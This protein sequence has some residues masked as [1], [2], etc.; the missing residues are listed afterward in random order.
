MPHRPLPIPNC[1]EP[2]Q[3]CR[4][5]IIIVSFN[6]REKLARCL[7]SIVKNLTNDTEVIVV[8]N[9]SW[10]SNAEMVESAY[11]AVA[12]IRSETNLGFATG[13]N[14][15]VR[16][17]RGKYLVFLNPDTL[18]ENNW[19][20]NLI[21]P[22]EEKSEV[23]IITPKI[24][25]SDR[26]DTINACGT[27][28]H[29]TGLSLCRGLGLPRQR[30][31]G[32]GEVGAISGAA[33]AIRRELFERLGG[34]DEDMFLYMEDIDLSLRAR[35]TGWQTYYTP[36]CTIFHDYELRVTPLKVFWQERN[37]YLMLLKIFKW[38]TL[39]LLLP[40][41]LLAE[42]I[43]W[44]F[45]FIHDRQHLMNKLNAYGWVIRNW[46]TILGKRAT[47]QSLRAV[48]DREL[49]KAMTDQ[50][51]FGQASSGIVARLAKL[52]FTPIF[53]LLRKFILAIVWW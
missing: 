20:E 4:S 47:T 11:P 5:S 53:Y 40:V 43:T 24:L 21:R 18:V 27:A 8:D 25:L 6:A 35:L 13:C 34:F 49:L 32:F 26:P 7:D 29:L 19:L 9:A 22:F 2:H 30:Y 50:L 1:S 10:E 15:G 17:A 46:S 16:Q 38:R 39:I 42:M 23:G 12:L 44:S 37:R 33:F 45:V 28:V 51:D 48:T 3:P 36:D 41:Y 14:L 52:I 31:D